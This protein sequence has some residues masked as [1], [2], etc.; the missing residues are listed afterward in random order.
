MESVMD[1]TIRVCLERAQAKT[2][3]KRAAR[4]NPHAAKTIESAPARNPYSVTI[5]YKPA[6]KFAPKKHQPRDSAMYT[7]TNIMACHREL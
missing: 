5:Q 4:A 6:L 3:A 1:E 2:D 7:S